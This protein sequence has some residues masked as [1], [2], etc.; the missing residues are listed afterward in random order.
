MADKLILVLV[1]TNPANPMEL[2]PP[3]FQATVAAAMEYDVEVIFTG[4][5]CEL[6]LNGF[7]EKIIIPGQKEKTLYDIIKDAHAAGVSFKV[8]TP[9]LEIWG[10]D[11]I[12]EVDET[13]GGAYVIGEAMDDSTV[14]FTY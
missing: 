9:T 2:G 4:R 8:C 3:F 14:T 13:V 12:K 1:N 11:F 5:T 6:A 10:N 7:S